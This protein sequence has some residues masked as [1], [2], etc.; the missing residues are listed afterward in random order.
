MSKEFDFSFSVQAEVAPGTPAADVSNHD[1]PRF[2]D[3]GSGDEIELSAEFGEAMPLA[4][5]MAIENAL[6][7]PE[8]A[9]WFLEKAR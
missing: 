2:S 4:L 9:E 1:D 6:E 7:D 3:P 8:V 5:R